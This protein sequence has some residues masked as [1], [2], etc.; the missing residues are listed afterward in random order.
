MDQVIPSSS[1]RSFRIVLKDRTRGNR[2][3][4]HST[5]PKDH[6]GP[7]S[8]K[9]FSDKTGKT[10]TVILPT[11]EQASRVALYANNELLGGY[12]DVEIGASFGRIVTHNS[13]LDWMADL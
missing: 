2:S 3:D 11:F 13:F 4:I 12:L 8:V 5:V 1:T 6:A 7:S 10:H 9:Y